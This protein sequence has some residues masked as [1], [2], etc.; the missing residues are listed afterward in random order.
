MELK[1]AIL[2]LI[3]RAAT[4]LS[5]DVEKALADA[6]KR[7]DKG[8]PAKG[9]FNTILENV[10]LARKMNTPIC[11]DTGSLIFYIDVP[12]GHSEKTY[13]EAVNWAATE[14][15]SLQYLRP[16]AVDI[17]SGKNSGNNIGINAPYIHFRQWDQDQIRVRLMLKG[18]GSEN[19][20]AQ[21]KLPYPELKAGRDLAGVRKV[22]ID[23]VLKAQ[24]LGCAPGV[25]GVGIGGDRV[26]SYSLSKKQFFRKIGQ[27]NTQKDLC[28][29][30]TGLNRDLNQLQIG[31]MGFGG[32]TTVLD[33]FVEAQH[34]HPASYFVSI[35][36]TCWAFRRKSMTIKN[37]EV[38]YD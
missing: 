19:V 20:G 34:R 38:S 26:T 33:V 13:R 14:A 24:G 1:N 6:Y 12:V 32:K 29:L 18:G 21:Y 15:T 9:V 11:Q 7:E 3:R 27:R 25:I 23:A 10:R 5:P 16:N 31:P 22:I 28:E 2:E 4:D 37:G 35:S 8:T 17:I 36:Y 30:E